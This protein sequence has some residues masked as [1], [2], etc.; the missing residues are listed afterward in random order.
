M[1][2]IMSLINGKIALVALFTLVAFVAQAQTQSMV[3]SKKVQ[4]VA[5]KKA[6]VSND[7]S[8]TNLTAETR[9]YSPRIVSKGVHRVNSPAVG[10][11]RSTGN[12]ASEGYPMWTISKGV[13]R[14]SKADSYSLAKESKGKN[15]Q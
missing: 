9:T 1:K 10:E 12:V 8:V 6:F 15:N 4:K 2:A 3:V 11:A 13:H 5:N 7:E 14:T